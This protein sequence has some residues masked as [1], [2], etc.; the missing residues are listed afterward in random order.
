MSQGPKFFD[1]EIV[2]P[3]NW[4]FW[5]DSNETNIKNNFLVL[6]DGYPGVA[7]GWSIVNNTSYISISQGVGYDGNGERLETFSGVNFTPLSG[8]N[9]VYARLAL[10]DYDPQLG[11]GSTVTAVDIVTGLNLPVETYNAVEFTNV[12]GA[13]YIP[14]ACVEFS[15]GAVQSFSIASGCRNHLLMFDGSIDVYDGTINLNNVASGSIPCSALASPFLCNLIMNSGASVYFN[16]SGTSSVGTPSFPAASISAMQGNFHSL[17]G[18]SPIQLSSELRQ[19]NNTSLE[20]NP[21][22]GARVRIDQNAAG[23]DMAGNVYLTLLQGRGTGSIFGN[24][25]TVQGLVTTLKSA[26]TMNINSLAN[27]NLTSSSTMNVSSAS[28]MGVAATNNITFNAGTGPTPNTGY[29]F[30]VGTLEKVVIHKDIVDVYPYVVMHSGANISGN[31]SVS[32]GFAAPK[33]SFENKVLNSSF[34][35]QNTTSPYYPQVWQFSGNSLPPAFSILTNRSFGTGAGIWSDPGYYGYSGG[36]TSALRIQTSGLQNV[37]PTSGLSGSGTYMFSIPIGDIRPD[38]I[39]TLKVFSAVADYFSTAASGGLYTLRAN[40]ASTPFDLSAGSKIYD[41]VLAL[42]SPQQ[43][44]TILN[45]GALGASNPS[46]VAYLNFGA[47]STQ[48]LEDFVMSMTDIQL[49]E[50]SGAVTVNN[51]YA[52]SFSLSQT[53]SIDGTHTLTVVPGLTVDVYSKGQ[54]AMINFDIGVQQ[55]TGINNNNGNLDLLVDGVIVDTKYAQFWI[56]LG[57]GPYSSNTAFAL[58][59]SLYLTPGKHTITC[60]STFPSLAGGSVNYGR[61]NILLN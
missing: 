53:S 7:T 3:S 20:V 41:N 4:E 29:A 58:S 56:N 32:N 14:I 39:Y 10:S 48:P 43:I 9:I 25:I 28:D 2:Q 31:L 46:G 11:S 15:G 38:T 5:R 36:R 16:Q 51:T 57:G 24:N 45:S 35:N 42:D 52:G 44:S 21:V 33:H 54:F 22:A 59:K 13:A 8:N 40:I 55:A 34:N 18:L 37:I 61:L 23:T 1:N 60:Q 17:S 27:L 12:S 19:Y 6:T 26:S 49:V 47:S 50:G 30:R